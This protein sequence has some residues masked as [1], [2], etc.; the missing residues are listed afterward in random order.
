LPEEGE[1]LLIRAALAG[2]SNGVA[3]R[4]HPRRDLDVV[5]SPL[6]VSVNV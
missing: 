4:S 2:L 6:D 5:N 1:R 3:E